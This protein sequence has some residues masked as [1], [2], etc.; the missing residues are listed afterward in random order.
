MRITQNMLN[1]SMLRNLNNSL[2]RMEKLQEMLSSGK[3]VSKPS[4][5]PV[6][7]A[8]GMF[9]RTAMTENEQFQSNANKAVSELQTVESAVSEGKDVLLRI[10]ELM[11]QA[12]NDTMSVG[13]RQKI[14]DELIQLRDHLGS[15]ANTT[16]AGVYLFSGT[17]TDN[18]PYGELDPALQQKYKDKDGKVPD[19]VDPSLLPFASSK[20]Y[21]NTNQQPILRELSQQIYLPVNVNGVKLF[22][23]QETD[24]L[25]G[26]TDIPDM[27]PIIPQPSK[28]VNVKL[29]KTAAGWS[30]N[31]AAMS[32]NASNEIEY[33]GVKFD[34]SGVTA[35][36][37]DS[38]NIQLKTNSTALFKATL[39]ASS[40]NTGSGTI[41]ANGTF[42]GVIPMPVPSASATA[43]PVALPD[44]SV[45]PSSSWE[46]G[47]KIT[48]TFNTELDNTGDQ[49]VD[50]ITKKFNKAFGIVSPNSVTVNVI[51]GKTFEVDP[52]SA[53]PLSLA[54]GRQVEFE[55]EIFK[56]IEGKGNE[57][58]ISFSIPDPIRPTINKVE[59][60]KNATANDQILREGD[61][62]VIT[63]DRS[64]NKIDPKDPDAASV[65]AAA[66]EKQFGAGKVTVTADAAGKSFSIV[67]NKGQYVNLENG[68]MITIP[69]GKLTAT[70][71]YP[72]DPISF[73]IS[74][75]KS[76]EQKFQQELSRL[77][78]SY[79]PWRTDLFRTMDNIINDLKP[80]PYMTDKYGRL[81]AADATTGEPIPEKRTVMV[82]G[83][84][85]EYEV[86]KLYDPN[87]SA[88][89]PL[90]KPAEMAQPKAGKELNGYLTILEK[91]IDNFLQVQSEIGARNNRVD[92]IQNRLDEQHQMIEK[93]MSDE[94]DADLAQ[95]IMELQNNEN[96]H[97]AALSAGS[98]IIQPTLLDFLR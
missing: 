95:V 51:D 57:G 50:E 83:Q 13:D 14:R 91:H 64:V 9:Y 40:G 10:K 90:M 3:K 37:G 46:A 84:P 4:D 78:E 96:V 36:T 22:G 52:G 66:I 56:N 44:A 74:D 98:R 81:L 54:G 20:G 32:V 93:S 49:V 23:Q 29:E 61:E 79:D 28:T 97:K 63:F 76:D 59:F 77:S 82:N 42:E 58:E 48:L 26:R 68:K 31:G 72:N 38:W 80:S 62:V 53:A 8:R 45:P 5:D 17:D 19:G 24:R 7:V 39:Q 75:P 25:V 16:H 71:S 92:M 12:S 35:N 47:Q 15:V 73:T 6:A 27:P 89:K 86:Y 55:K 88:Q 21:T 94:E 30:L 11:T 34:L 41:Q 60:K 2:T 67:V 33:R 18:A 65:V 87:D 1:N 69:S 43:L 85:V 70:D